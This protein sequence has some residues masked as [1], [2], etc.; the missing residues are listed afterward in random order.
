MRRV[1]VSGSYE[2]VI[3]G[4]GSAGCVLANRLSEDPHTKVLLLEAGNPDD[5]QSIHVPL[6]WWGLP[7][8]VVDWCYT[9]TPQPGLNGRVDDWPRG[10]T[11]GGSSAIN[12]MMYIRG[13][14]WD[15]DRWERIGNEGWSYDDL[16]P[17]FK[18]AEDF[19]DGETA[20]HGEDGPL[21]VARAN[22]PI[23]PSRALVE[24]AQEAGFTYNS[25]FNGKRQSGVGPLHLTAVN[26]QRQSTAVAYLHPSLIRDNLTATTG[27]HVTRVLFDGS[28][29]TGVEYEHEGSRVSVSATS[30]VILSAGAIESPK[31]LMLSGVGPADELA[32]HGIDC[33]EDLPGVG[34]NLQD[35][36]QAAVGYE[37]TRAVSYPTGSNGIENTAFERTAP[38]LPAP[39]VQYIL[40]P[41]DAALTNPHG[42][43]HLLITA[44]VLRPASRGQITLQSDDPFDHPVI[45]PQYFSD[46]SDLDTLVKGVFRA[47]EMMSGA[48]LDTYRGIETAPGDSV[49]S[50]EEMA[51]YVRNHASTIYHP[52]GTCKM[53]DD[54]LAVV[55]DRLRVI[56]LDSLRIVDASI[57][58]RITSGNTNAPTIAIAERAADL[59]TGAA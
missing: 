59:I 54:A 52:V 9:T 57:M 10:R 11:L 21:G 1:S 42:K 33:R 51:Q 46:S 27:A 45:D 26:G 56:G 41:T 49:Q 12:A 58:P 4:A 8:S 38:D 6:L 25:D 29:A 28:R 3:V 18:R 44:I 37:C 23:A 43:S 40:W 14:R 32:R 13:N 48:A 22:S 35:H 19:E 2:Y 53:G 50:T 24:A 7:Q 34:R 5:S 47:R 15:Y 30:E 55:D 36:V 31:L 16:L 17:Y 20:F 39:D